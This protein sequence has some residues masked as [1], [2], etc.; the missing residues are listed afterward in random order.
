LRRPAARLLAHGHG[1]TLRVARAARPFP[2]VRFSSTSTP[3]LGAHPAGPPT[4]EAVAIV[5]AGDAPSSASAAAVP[6][7][8]ASAAAD[9]VLVQ[10]PLVQGP[11]TLEQ[12][13]QPAAD[14][15]FRTV[16]VP[17]LVG[18]TGD[19][20]LITS[21]STGSVVSDA[22]TA[23]ADAAAAARPDTA[24]G[25]FFE[26]P[27]ALIEF[28]LT[29]V[30]DTTGLPWYLTIALTTASVR[31]A[32]VPL[33]LYQSR[34]IAK[35]ATLKPQIDELSALMKE[36]AAK[37][38]ER[39]VDEAER[40]RR[41]L[42]A[43]FAQHN[44]KP[45]MSIVGALGQI[46]LW[47]T[48]FFTLRHVTRPGANLGFETG[49][50][51]WFEDL[52]VNDPYYILPCICGASFYGM[53]QLGDPGQAGAPIDEKTKTMRTFMSAV[54]V[55]MVPLTSWFQTGI[56]V[57]WI[58][59]NTFAMTQTLLLRQPAVRS[60]VGMPP[61]PTHAAGV[62][63]M[64]PAQAAAATPKLLVHAESAPNTELSLGG[65]LPPPASSLQPHTSASG[66]APPKGKSKG[67]RR[68]RR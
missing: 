28:L 12:M 27:M 3:T 43:L 60:F 24:G 42:S 52:T 56:F 67:K 30:H 33:Q 7:P 31:L 46:P 9:A 58:S 65:S 26:K 5:A 41:A 1:S 48:F 47:L 63:G 8:S 10:G 50:A 37:N 14:V 35:M 20:A 17:V 39:G 51:L 53:V 44:L 57:Y 21:A 61:L 15:A 25:F 38:T 11:L 66:S 18:P 4:A 55:G 40:H 6:P 62:L 19:T 16:P 54:A 22:F 23:A 36:A 34:S 29:T 13:T 64:T 49:G 59:T 32:F 45:W 68:R 2:A